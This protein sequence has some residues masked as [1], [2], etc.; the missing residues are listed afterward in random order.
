M[1]IAGGIAV[2]FDSDEPVAQPACRQR[3]LSACSVHVTNARA[4]RGV[5]CVSTLQLLSSPWSVFAGPIGAMPRALLGHVLCS[6]SL[7]I[8]SRQHIWIASCLPWQPSCGAASK[9]TFSNLA[10]D[11]A[12]ASIGAR[13]VCCT[14]G[15]GHACKRLHDVPES[16]S[17]QQAPA[18]AG[19]FTKAAA[20]VMYA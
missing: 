20:A 8:C 19:G 18:A 9:G 3:N 14:Q 13:A 4:F 16:R 11:R 6:C 7:R 1:H 10:K 15:S 5:I 17:W 2:S 12:S